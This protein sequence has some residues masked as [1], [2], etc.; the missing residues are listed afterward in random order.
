M[1]K[2]AAKGMAEV[3]ETQLLYLL[4]GDRRVLLWATRLGSASEAF[5]RVKTSGWTS[6]NFWLQYLICSS[7]SSTRR[8]AVRINQLLKSE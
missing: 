1:A 4:R 8:S 7:R 3:V 2:N 6:C 5:A